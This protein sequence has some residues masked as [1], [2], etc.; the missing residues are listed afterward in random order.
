MIRFF[1]TYFPART[2]F[3]GISEA[4]LVA[5]A[6]IIAT[7]ARLGANDANLMLNYEQGFLKITVV[8]IVF[9]L[10][11][12]YFDLYDSLVL[13]NRREVLTRLVQVLGTVCIMLALLYFLFPPLQLG[14]GIFLLGFVLVAFLLFAWRRL[15]LVVNTMPQFA[16]RALVLGDGPLAKNLIEEIESRKELGIRVAA[17]LR[18]IEDAEKPYASLTEAEKFESLSRQ[19]QSYR[20]SRIIV[21]M[22]DRRGK[23]PV[24]ALLQL[25]SSG[26]QVQDGAEVYEAITGK[27]PL[28]S[29]RLSWLLF[30]PSFYV[31]R[32][33]LIYK[34]VVST[35]I[36]LV[37]L[38]ITAPIMAIAAIAI[39]LDS[40]GPIIFRQKR[41]GEGGRL[42]TL[43]K[44]R[45]MVDGVEKDEN[46]RPA[47]KIDGRFTRVGAWLRRTRIDELPQLINI[48]RGD[49]H[50]VGP[51]PFVENQEQECLEKIPFYRQRWSVKP[52]ATGWAQVNRGYCATIED[53]T[54][55]L[56]Y[57]LFYIKNIS[58]GLDLLILFKTIKIL[59]L[60]RGSR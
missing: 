59:L 14:R 23:L 3:L 7:F 48:L 1:H 32:P 30:S 33:L 45:T 44:F 13:S 12:Y 22:G 29:L 37:C 28:E 56:A 15:F 17:H 4:L 26:I 36:S 57:D 53:N 9:I 20:A 39:R 16:Q 27:V 19:V 8:A 34:R 46:F 5:I 42:F 60:G 41:V 52:G 49:M 58:I 10:C 43:Y 18:E 55:K 24:E 50:F 11:M 35:F 51:R 40:P 54:E 2:L 47:E 31:S 6:F 38:I 21:G 25:K